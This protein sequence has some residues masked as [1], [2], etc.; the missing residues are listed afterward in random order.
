M[1]ELDP[2]HAAFMLDL[3]GDPWPDKVLNEMSVRQAALAIV[4]DKG[5]GRWLTFL[6]DQHRTDVLAEAARQNPDKLAIRLA[7]I[8]Y[9][10]TSELV[11][12]L[13]HDPDAFRSFTDKLS[14][15]HLVIFIAGANLTP[16]QLEPL[17]PR[18]L[19]AVKVWPWLAAFRAVHAAAPDHAD[20]PDYRG[21]WNWIRTL[22]W[23][24][25]SSGSPP[26]TGRPIST[27]SGD[28]T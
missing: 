3:A 14:E 5:N 9:A 15:W 1:N 19:A 18:L 2:S 6:K 7:Q 25:G 13:S 24:G 22:G 27:N 10:R 12:V 21:T 16:E 23:I 26:R 28:A 17:L 20:I 8:P 11:S 4:S